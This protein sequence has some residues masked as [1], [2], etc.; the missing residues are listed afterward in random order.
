MLFRASA[1]KNQL[2]MKNDTLKCLNRVLTIS[3]L[4][5]NCKDEEICEDKPHIRCRAFAKWNTLLQKDSLELTCVLENMSGCVLDQ[6]WTLCLRV[7]SVRS[8]YTGGTSRTYSFALK[9]LDC[10]QNIDVTIPLDGDWDIFLPVQLHCLLVYSLQSLLN[11]EQS[12][13]FPVSQVLTDT[14]CITLPLRTVTLDWLDVLRSPEPCLHTGGFAKQLSSWEATRMLLSSR[15]LHEDEAGP[16]PAPHT[17]TMNISSDLLR[18][19]LRIQD[20]SSLVLCVSVLKWLLCGTSKEADQRPVKS[21]MVCVRGP[22]GHAVRLL[23]KEVSW[24]L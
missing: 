18:N 20:G 1:L 6:G 14:R 12:R 16:S 4:L 9:K 15:R 22:D 11:P 23:T 24:Y 17:V 13:T 2:K 21:P 3:H 5:L 7:Q 8:H 10:G 19:R